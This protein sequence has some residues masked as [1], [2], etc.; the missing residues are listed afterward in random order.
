MAEL[1]SRGAGAA[2]GSWPGWPQDKWAVLCEAA[3]VYAR[4]REMM[5]QL[6]NW[7]VDA[8]VGEAGV[9]VGWGGGAELGWAGCLKGA[10]GEGILGLAFTPAQHLQLGA[11][12]GSQAGTVAE[13]HRLAGFIDRLTAEAGRV[14]YP[15]DPLRQRMAKAG[16]VWDPSLLP[17]LRWAAQHAAAALMAHA[18]GEAQEAGK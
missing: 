16:L 8:Q 17:D 18:L 15:H 1:R 6:L 13:S 5:D 7:T 10:R 14:G 11:L 2:G 12:P 4:L 3:D 9:E